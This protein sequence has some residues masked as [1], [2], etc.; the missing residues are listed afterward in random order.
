MGWKRRERRLELLRRQP[1][2]GGG[3]RWRRLYPR[4]HDHDRAG[5]F[6][7]DLGEQ[8]ERV[9]NANAAL[10]RDLLSDRAFREKTLEERARPRVREPRL[11]DRQRSGEDDAART[12]GHDLLGV[13]EGETPRSRTCQ[14]TDQAAGEVNVELTKLGSGH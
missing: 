11:F 8:T 3:R 6:R 13:L 12:L 14:V 9:G 10:A 4:R 5:A 2:H 1:A 7:T